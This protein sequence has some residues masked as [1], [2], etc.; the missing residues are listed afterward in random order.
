MMSDP[1]IAAPR[2][3]VGPRNRQWARWVIAVMIALWVAAMLSR[4]V[5]RAHWWT[6]RLATVEQPAERWY[7][8][9]C[10]ASLGERAIG[11]VGTLLDHQDPAV[12]L[13]ATNVLCQ[14]ESDA[15]CDALIV[16]AGGQD[17]E[18][19][20][21]AI[22]ALSLR[23]DDRARPTMR[24][25]LREGDPR[26]AM[27]VAADYIGESLDATVEVLA[28][29]LRHHPNP[30]VRIEAVVRME[31]LGSTL[32]VPA[33][34][35]ALVD[36]GVFHGET[37]RDIRAQA[38]WRAVRTGTQARS[39]NAV[40]L[41]LEVETHYIVSERALRALHVL[42]DRPPADSAT[43]PID[44]AALADNWRT[45]WAKQSQRQDP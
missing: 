31:E 35:D 11:P 15:S 21:V 29:A 39:L 42:T 5:I 26:T 7:Y 14:S 25:W 17:I 45:W 24:E 12:R 2:S 9:Q 1:P 43:A 18:V 20:R 8:S 28:D 19:K 16:G 37:E 27:I 10:L 22:R 30:G 13:L 40:T 23:E 3:P 34:I 36:D 41:D 38:M 33:L 32:A 6:H 44:H 4:N